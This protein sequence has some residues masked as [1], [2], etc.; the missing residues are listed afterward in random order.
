MNNLLQL[1]RQMEEMSRY[2]QHVIHVMGR[3]LR[4]ASAAPRFQGLYAPAPSAAL[5][6]TFPGPGR[7]NAVGVPLAAPGNAVGLT[8][9]APGNAV[10]LFPAA[11]GN[12]EGLPLAASG[13]ASAQPPV[14]PGRLEEEQKPASGHHQTRIGRELENLLNPDRYAAGN[15]SQED[16]RHIIGQ[17]GSNVDNIYDLAPGQLWMLEAVKRVKSAFFLQILT[18]AVIRLDLPGFRQQAE[19]VCRK[20]ETL[21]AAF[22][23]KNTDRPYRVILKHRPPEINCFDLSDLTMEEF[24]QKINACME[25]D[26]QRGFDLERDS[27]FRINIYKSCDEDTYAIVISQPHINSDGTSLGIIFRDLFMGYVLDMNGIDQKIVSHSYQ[28]YAEHLSSVDTDKELDFWKDALRDIDEDQLLPGQQVSSLDYKQDTLFVP[29]EENELAA[30]KSAVKTF[31][32]TEFTVLQGLWGLTIARLK[33]RD[34]MVYGAITAGRD[35]EVSDSMMITGGFVNAIPAVIRIEDGEA[36]ADYFRRVQ[37]NFLEFMKHSHVAPDQI[38]EAAGRKLPV[39][40]HLLNNHNFAAPKGA[41]FQGGSMSG[42]QIIGGDVYDNLSEDLCVYFTMVDGKRGCNYSY[43]SRAFSK[44]VI[45]LLSGYLKEIIKELDESKMEGTIGL[46]HL[47]DPGL[48]EAAQDARQMEAAKIAGYL[49]KHPIF[50]EAGDED[51]VA[52]SD[53]CR[54]ESF[55]EEEIV[56]RE[57]ES[58]TE[59]PILLSGRCIQYGRTK[60]GWNNPLSVIKPGQILDF[61]FFYENG[62]SPVTVS[63]QSSTASV[64]FIPRE[65]LT[66]F[67]QKY[68]MGIAEI[69]RM[70][71]AGRRKYLRLWMRAQ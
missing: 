52:L 48:I 25:A 31:K 61:S 63:T 41:G 37:K 23:M 24:D 3:M 57:G 62:R 16:L 7:G 10:G 65:E 51:L 34:H 9:A 69:A 50:K 22:V 36:L 33:H 18:K 29:F 21:R 71:D 20:H 26:R 47:S 55:G 11:R 53:V 17:Y 8:P 5:P 2:N 12:A 40:S 35:T 58:N 67:L 28:G 32:V 42:V 30:L 38:R 19:E 39:F 45:Q 49:K 4:G 59:I 60:E 44:E 68:P 14:A 64:I 54:I 43:N 6:G 70:M 13:N 1:Q 15:L 46:F 27:L 66:R 56:I